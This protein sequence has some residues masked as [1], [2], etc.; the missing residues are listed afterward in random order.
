MS[1]RADEGVAVEARPTQEATTATYAPAARFPCFDGLR[2]I[3]ALSVFVCH[4]SGWLWYVDRGWAPVVVQSSLS[5]LGYYGVAVFFVISGFLLYRPFVLSHFEDRPPPAAGRFWFRRG[6]RVFP[7]YWAALLGAWLVF[8]QVDM[9]SLGDGVMYFGLLQTYREGF[10]YVGIGVAWTLVIEVSFYVAL[11]GIAW[12]LRRLSRRDA[13]ARTRLRNQLLGIAALGTMSVIVRAV[14]LWKWEPGPA[15]W[16]S[17][18]PL[19]Q[20]GMWLIGYLDW[21]A[22]GMAMAVGSA[23]LAAG[24]RLP[25]WI[26]VLASRSGWCWVVSAVLLFGVT[27]LGIPWEPDFVRIAP[28]AEM[29][30]LMLSLG[31]AG[32]LVFPAVFGDQ[33]QGIVRKFLRT[34]VLV[35]LG[36]VSYGVYL[37]H[38]VIWSASFQ[39]VRDGAIPSGVV[40]QFLIVLA[41]TVGVATASYLLIERPLRRWATRATRR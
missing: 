7:A 14:Y 22:V 21:F 8:G 30:R 33:S 39:W 31:A 37:W 5:R 4:S 34:R 35:A 28:S 6:V 29:A 2:A 38:Q 18:L 10:K 32:F 26:G 9:R 1:G 11:P 23:W 24:G 40:P 27:R 25:R 15:P 19:N 20:A 3:A 12:V 41:V 17:W 13:P 16:G 36:L